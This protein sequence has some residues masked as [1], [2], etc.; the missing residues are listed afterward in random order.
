[1]DELLTAFAEHNNYK[2]DSSFKKKYHYK[3]SSLALN[4]EL[5]A[6]LS[7]NK[8]SKLKREEPKALLR[9]LSAQKF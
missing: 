6:K 8:I 3:E 9:T 7:K 4:A 2:I 5:L 1:M